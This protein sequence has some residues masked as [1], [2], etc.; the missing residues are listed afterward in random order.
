MV[1][2]REQSEINRDFVNDFGRKGVPVWVIR[3]YLEDTGLSIVE[4]QARTSNDKVKHNK[5]MW[6][7]FAHAH[8]VMVQPVADQKTNHVVVMD[9]KGKIFDP[10]NKQANGSDY[11]YVITVLGIFWD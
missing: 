11:Y 10:D 6:E 5:R 1:L 4:K 3:E 8:I 9:R 7:P 2:G